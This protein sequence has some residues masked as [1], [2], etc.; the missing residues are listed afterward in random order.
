MAPEVLSRRYDQ[1]ADVWSLGV[2]LYLLLSGLAPFY[3]GT[4]QEIFD[5]VLT[6]EVDFA[7]PPWPSVSRLGRDLMQRMLQ[8]DPRKR[9]TPVQVLQVRA[10]GCRWRERGLPA[11]LPCVPRLAQGPSIFCA[12]RS[13]ATPS[14]R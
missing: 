2:C 5:M 11:S 12:A 4:E 13:A 14:S 9:P 7:S 1:Q 6:A 3:G 8:R 10:E